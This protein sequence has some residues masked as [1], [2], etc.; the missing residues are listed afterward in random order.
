MTCACESVHKFPCQFP[1][2]TEFFDFAGRQWCRF[3]L[4]LQDADG[5]KSAKVRGDNGWEEGGVEW[6]KFAVEIHDR[7]HAALRSSFLEDYTRANLQGVAIPPNFDFTGAADKFHVNFNRASFGDEVSFDG[8]AFTNEAGFVDAIFGGRISFLSGKFGHRAHFEGA[9]FSDDVSFA[10]TTFSGYA[11]FEGATFGGG[12]NFDGATFGDG[13]NFDCTTFCYK[14]N[15][16]AATFGNVTRF[17]RATFE[18]YADFSDASF[19]VGI[20]FTQAIFKDVADFS[21]TAPAP[22]PDTARRDLALRFIS[23]RK[24]IFNGQAIFENRAFAT[25]SLFDGAIFENLAQFHGCEFHQGMF[26]HEADFR[27]TIGGNN[28]QTAELEQS[29]R[30][31]KRAMAD[32]HARNEEADFFALEMECRRQRGSVPRLERIVATAYKIFS[33]YGRS[34]A[35]PLVWM[36]F[37]LGYGFAYF[38]HLAQAKSFRAPGHVLRFVMEQVVTP[39]SIWTNRYVPDPWMADYLKDHPMQ[40]RVPATLMTLMAI[41]LIALFLLALRRRFK[42]D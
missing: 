32:L 1:G 29:Y 9:I 39:F 42:M 23:F 12:V 36:G 22:N 26:F 4:P 18:G 20:N 2:E 17:E 5:N 25:S 41:T 31:L 40:L 8:T 13:A 30:T 6:R 11:G 19:G 27:K 34:I 24:A 7:L 33:D 16:K 35:R 3:H 37:L 38:Y 28:T 15:F 21:D 10:G 14:A